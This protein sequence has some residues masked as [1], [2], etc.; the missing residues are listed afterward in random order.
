MSKSKSHISI[1]KVHSV[2]QE[3]LDTLRDNLPGRGF[4][5][6]LSH[7]RLGETLP[8]EDAT[9]VSETVIYRSTLN[10]SCSVMN[11]RSFI[12]STEV[13]LCYYGF[14]SSSDRELYFK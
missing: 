5:R 12:I 3:L 1:R 7:A 13:G 4:C 11:F 6:R 9:D 2:G 8:L 14:Y 10:F